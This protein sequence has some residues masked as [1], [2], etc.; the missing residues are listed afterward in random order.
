MVT[1]PALAG[2]SVVTVHPSYTE[3]SHSCRRKGDAAV[4][5]PT[6]LMHGPRKIRSPRAHCAR[7]LP[8]EQRKQGDGLTWSQGNR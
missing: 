2:R 1:P 8:A 7:L 3:Q 4:L 5:T 6:L